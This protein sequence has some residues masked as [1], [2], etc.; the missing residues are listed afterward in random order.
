VHRYRVRF[1]LATASY[2]VAVD[3][4]GKIAGLSL[5]PE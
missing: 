4:A 3:A 2:V 5:N 1:R